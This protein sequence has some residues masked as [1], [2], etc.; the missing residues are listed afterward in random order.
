[1]CPKKEGTLNPQITIDHQITIKNWVS[2]VFFNSLI[3]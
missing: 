3:C 2:L 1:L